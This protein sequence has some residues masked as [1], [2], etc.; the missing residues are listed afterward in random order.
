MSTQPVRKVLRGIM[1]CTLL[2]KIVLIINLINIIPIIFSNSYNI[3]VNSGT[4][5]ATNGSVQEVL[6]GVLATNRPVREVLGGFDGL[7]PAGP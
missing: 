7:C 6:D 2:I 4:K 1:G 5:L 3:I